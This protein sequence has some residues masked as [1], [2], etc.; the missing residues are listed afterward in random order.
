MAILT[1]S[2]WRSSSVGLKRASD[3][4]AL[5]RVAGL[6]FVATAPNAVW[7]TLNVH[8]GV[9]A[10]VAQRMGSVAQFGYGQSGNIIA[11]MPRTIGLS[12]LGTISIPGQS[13]PNPTETSDWSKIKL[14]Y[15]AMFD[16]TLSRLTTAVLL[17]S[18]RATIRF[19]SGTTQK[20]LMVGTTI[21]E[22]AN[23]TILPKWVAWHTSS[24]YQ[25]ALLSSGPIDLS[26]MDQPWIMVWWGNQSHWCD[27]TKPLTFA[28]IAL[29]ET[30]GLPHRYAFQADA[31]LLLTFGTNPASISQDASGGFDLTWSV[32]SDKI[33]ILP[34]YGRTKL[35]AGTTETW[36]SAIPTDV[37]T[38]I[39]AW[40]PR[41]CQFPTGVSEAYSYNSGTDVITITPTFTWTQVNAGGSKFATIPPNIGVAYDTSLDIVCSETIIDGSMPTEWGPLLGC[42]GVDS[43]NL[44]ITGLQPFVEPRLPLGGGT[45]P[46]QLQTR[47]NAEV[48]K[49]VAQTRWEPWGVPTRAPNP[50]VGGDVYYS[51]PADTFAQAAEVLPTLSGSEETALKDWLAA[52]LTATTPLSTFKI[53]AT[54]GTPRGLAG[55]EGAY[56]AYWNTASM[57]PVTYLDRR[58]TWVA[59]ALARYY[60]ESGVSIPAGTTDDLLDI[61]QV[62]M[63]E[64]SWDLGLWLHGFGPRQSGLENANRLLAGLIG[65][66][67]FASEQA[68]TDADDVTVVRGLY[69]RVACTRIAMGH[70][71]RWLESV[72]L[73]TLPT[74]RGSANGAWVPE[75]G[76][77]GWNGYTLTYDWLSSVDDPR[78]VIKWDQYHVWLDTSTSR[79]GWVEGALKAQVPDGRSLTYNVAKLL[80]HASPGE[81]IIPT[82]KRRKFRPHE[83]IPFADSAYGQ[84]SNYQQPADSYGEF[85][86]RAWGED[87][88]PVVLEVEAG[89]PWLNGGG[90]I[91]TLHKLAEAYRAYAGEAPARITNITVNSTTLNKGQK[92][93]V[94]FYV[95]SNATRPDFPY[96][97][98]TVVPNL[99]TSLGINATLTLTHVPT[100]QVYVKDAFHYDAFVWQNVTPSRDW[101][102]PDYNNQAPAGQYRFGARVSLPL[103][104]I[105]NLSIQFEDADG[106]EPAVAGP[107]ITVADTPWKGFVR[108][109][110]NDSRYFEREDGTFLPT[111]GTHLTNFNTQSP[112]LGNS[113]ITQAGIYK[114]DY[115]RLW[116]TTFGIFGA[117]AHPWRSY[118]HGGNSFTSF[119]TAPA[120]GA[121]LD[122]ELALVLST[123]NLAVIWGNF[124]PGASVK[125]NTLYQVKLRVKCEDIVRSNASFPGGV[126]I[127]AQNFFINNPWLIG[128]ES[129]PSAKLMNPVQTTNG[130]EEFTMSW[131]TGTFAYPFFTIVLEN[132]SSGIAYIDSIIVREDLG[133]GNY[134]PNIV[135]KPTMNMH[136]Y[137][138]QE[139]AY[140]WDL[141]MSLV[142]AAGIS[143][144][145]VVGEKNDHAIGCWDETTGLPETPTE[146]NYYGAADGSMTKARWLN[147]AW[148]RYVRARWGYSEAVHSWELLN[149]GTPN[150]GRHYLLAR[151][152]CDFM[153]ADEINAHM[154]T[155]SFF[156]SLPKSS[157]WENPSYDNADYVD[158]HQYIGPEGTTVVV[159]GGSNITIPATDYNDTAEAYWRMANAIGAGGAQDV[160]GKPIIWAE[161]ALVNTI[162][163]TDTAANLQSDTA[164][165]WLHKWLW[166]QLHAPKIHPN[167]FNSPQLLTPENRPIIQRFA[168]FIE[169]IPLN[170]GHYVDAVPTAPTG[171]KA[172]GQKDT[173]NNAF[174]FWATN[175]EHN[176]SS[177]SGGT[178]RTGDIV[179]NNL[180]AGIYNVI[181]I[182]PYT[183]SIILNENVA[184]DDFGTITCTLPASLT[185]DIAVKASLISEIESE[186]MGLGLADRNALIGLQFG[187]TAYTPPATYYVALV[188]D[189]SDPDPSNWPEISTAVW[190]NYAREAVTNNT[191]NFSDPVNGH[192]QNDVAIDFGV[193]SVTGTAPVIKGVVLRDAA[194]AGNVRAAQ[195]IATENWATVDNNDP[196]V[197]EVG[198]LDL[199]LTA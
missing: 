148:W 157:Y 119:L 178:P 88:E 100:Q 46:S 155:T 151:D 138:S 168:T 74:D 36:G 23:Q 185:T 41:T 166:A 142:E 32:A 102:G 123:T 112:L 95:T 58:D 39:Q 93:E 128:S 109:A 18:T 30:R 191:T 181:W 86:C 180:T 189:T 133:A 125:T 24:G 179:I 1:P 186:L 118:V 75:I 108:V 22:S 152:F 49:L 113:Y 68:P 82:K 63:L 159:T 169:T 48:T 79:F 117:Y 34:L 12:A 149:E 31:P 9:T 65:I 62:D 98:N 8:G 172:V 14:S 77:S 87:L 146:N 173:T 52:E 37:Q 184:T 28:D 153:H 73:V 174:H 135:A 53:S 127:K 97:P 19:C 29:N 139:L 3:P 27:T 158:I 21:N 33:S 105:W 183:G 5:G 70:L 59:H 199:T 103:A 26:G 99:D 78:T 40:W 122:H 195:A 176:R 106:L 196:V 194:S 13:V 162:S 197:I 71:P 187:G 126:T 43:Y 163:N 164:G 81:L 25:T 90:D 120:S 137:V 60:Q 145:I 156:S 96:D 170:N 89:Y 110:Q 10:P 64:Q 38:R 104:G 80:E 134:G 91:M 16:L 57:E 2:T 175:T 94:V 124:L 101:I 150:D 171:V 51:D 17:E 66:L 167:W 69:A 141:I 193:A 111:I 45:V 177:L 56:H 83:W 44:N 42:A 35:I 130:Y 107:N 47:I 114:I 154:A 84:E 165:I 132:V 198:N 121:Y 147:R 20:R 50:L 160:D 136:Q 129:S 72:G 61:L 85:L 4:Q 188:T 131:T 182:N 11:G 54:D 115:L 190:T 7:P 140:R 192:V 6:E 55:L 116:L 144:K 92:L 15:S 76:S 67:W 161:T 143:A